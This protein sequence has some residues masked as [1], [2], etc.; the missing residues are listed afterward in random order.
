M[1]GPKNLAIALYAMTNGDR[2]EAERLWG[3][4]ADTDPASWGEAWDTLDTYVKGPE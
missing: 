3:V 1:L 4:L 2:D